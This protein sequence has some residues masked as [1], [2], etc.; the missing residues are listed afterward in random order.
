[1]GT[2]VATSVLFKVD[3]GLCLEVMSRL[4]FLFLFPHQV[5]FIYQA[6][7]WQA[8]C[9]TPPYPSLP[10]PTTVAEEALVDLLQR[11]DRMTEKTNPSC[12][13]KEEA[14]PV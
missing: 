13:Q 5:E 11:V 9:A 10:C 1:M 4:V 14:M 8:C 2:E 3:R 12:P 6:M 7:Q